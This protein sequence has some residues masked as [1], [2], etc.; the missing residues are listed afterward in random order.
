MTRFEDP[1]LICSEIAAE[2]TFM[3]DDIGTWYFKAAYGVQL[4]DRFK[5]RTGIF[6]ALLNSDA[7]DFYIKH[8]TAL[9]VDGFYKYTTNYL[10]PLPVAWG[11]ENEQESIQKLVSRLTELLDKK[12]KV[13]RFPEAYVGEYDGEM[14]YIMYTWQT[15]R[16]P[17]NAEV[18]GDVNDNFVVQAGRSDTISDPV[19]YANKRDMR[20]RRAR[21]VQEAVNG[22]NVKSGEETTIPIPRSNQGVNN[23]LGRLNSDQEEFENTDLD[24]LEDRINDTIYDIYNIT[25]EQQDIIEG[26]LETFRVY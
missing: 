15:R 11:Q 8:Y 12:S 14:E 19:M 26:Y 9:K 1:K 5:D 24:Q 21:Y 13:E 10:T 16:Y 23:L 7:L 17:V 2:A 4:E 3:L 20:K 25:P 6:A 22:R 18:R